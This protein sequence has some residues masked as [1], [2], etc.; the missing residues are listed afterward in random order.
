MYLIFTLFFII[1][2]KINAQNH[3]LLIIPSYGISFPFL[4]MQKRFGVNHNG[5][6]S[7][8]FQPTSSIAIYTSFSVLFGNKV[9]ETNILNNLKNSYGFII[10]QNGLPGIY[11]L[12]EQG[13]ILR[14]GVGPPLIISS[15]LTFY[16]L[17]SI[18]YIWHKIKIVNVQN[19][20]PQLS[21]PYIFGYDRLSGGPLLEI[22][23]GISY[24]YPHS[25][26]RG[27]LFMDFLIARTKNLREYN[28]DTGEHD[29]KKRWDAL[30]TVS[31]GIPLN[32]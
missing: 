5:I 4:D 28:Y 24:I 13:Y 25:I 7:L 23:T 21:E 3:N 27:S 8:I 15:Y 17:L 14:G 9:K 20:I 31:L 26:L 12:R 29:T 1:F 10:D 30:L 6:I 16:P 2:F 11:Y 19:Q 18:G 22:S 32:F